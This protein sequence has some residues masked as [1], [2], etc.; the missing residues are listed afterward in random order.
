MSNKIIKRTTYVMIKKKI[1]R[2]KPGSSS[3]GIK[4]CPKKSSSVSASLVKV[5][6]RGT[7]MFQPSRIALSNIGRYSFCSV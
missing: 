6:Q 2:V 4:I 3:S 5:P 1:I 7:Q